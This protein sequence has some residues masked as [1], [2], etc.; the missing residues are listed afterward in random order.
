MEYYIVGN[1][2]KTKFLVDDE[3]FGLSVTDK[4]SKLTIFDSTKD[5]DY[6]LQI[7]LED[8]Q[9][10]VEN[11]T[12]QIVYAKEHHSKSAPYVEYQLGL[13]QELLELLNNKVIYEVEFILKEIE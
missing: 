2:D 10:D 7:N 6:D 11:Y 3:E 4:L 1:K 9:S 13:K 5:F 8:T 12:K